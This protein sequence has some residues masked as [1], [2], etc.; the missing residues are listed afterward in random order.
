MRRRAGVNEALFDRSNSPLVALIKRTSEESSSGRSHPL[1]GA[2]IDQIAG[3]R[4]ARLQREIIAR[5]GVSQPQ[6]LA[7]IL[8][9]LGPMTMIPVPHNH[10]IGLTITP[11][12][13]YPVDL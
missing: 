4:A 8:I 3:L 6:W 7:M 13:L 9:A 5:G 2:L 12:S 10:H 11:S 1:S